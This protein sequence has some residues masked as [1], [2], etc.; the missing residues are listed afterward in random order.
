MFRACIWY[1][2]LALFGVQPLA[3]Q[4]QP[5]PNLVYEAY[6]RVDFSDLEEWNRLYWTYSVPVLEALRDEGVIEGWSQ[7]Q[8]QTGGDGYNIRFTARTYDWAAID[9][10]WSE[11]FSRL[12][13]VTP[14]AEW[15][16]GGRLIA[17]HR[18]A[19]WDVERQAFVDDPE[20]THLYVSTFRVNFSD[21]SEWDDLWTDVVAP[22]L[23]EAMSEGILTGWVKLGHN[24]G[25]P[26]NS[27]VLYLFN[28]WDN[29]DDVFGKVLGTLAEEHPDQFAR[30][31]EIIE[32]HDDA[33]WTL[34]TRDEM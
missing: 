22:I 6:Y 28:G 7:G 3:S 10:F 24:T 32:A 19:I 30:I 14:E 20:V 12:Q 9:T 15:A 29:I 27:K 25:G 33:I 21:M 34:T 16:E 13:E 5:P 11:Y 1:C 31:N 8:H 2:A 4:E 17:E 23:G 26:H 18:D